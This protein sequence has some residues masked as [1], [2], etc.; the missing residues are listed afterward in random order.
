MGAGRRPAARGLRARRAPRPWPNARVPRVRRGR[1]P[2][3][4]AVGSA[5]SNASGKAG[6]AELAG[7]LLLVVGSDPIYATGGG[8]MR[9]ARQVAA[10]AA[11]AACA[12]ASPWGRPAGGRAGGE[13]RAAHARAAGGAPGRP[14]HRGRATLGARSPTSR[15]GAA[16]PASPTPTRS[17]SPPTARCTWSRD[18]SST[19]TGTRTARSSCSS[20]RRVLARTGCPPAR[21]RR[22]S[23]TW[24]HLPRA[25]PRRAERVLRLARRSGRL[26]PRR[27]VERAVVIEMLARAASRCA[28]RLY[29]R[30]IAVRRPPA[31][32]PVARPTRAPSRAGKLDEASGLLC[33]LEQNSLRGFGY[34]TFGRR[35]V[36]LLSRP[37]R[38]LASEVGRVRLPRRLGRVV[39]RRAAACPLSGSSA[40][41]RHPWACG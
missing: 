18:S 41:C 26:T 38:L 6:L 27:A 36:L 2:R 24:L 40:R 35:A 21:A 16:H 1:V 12:G 7:R 23:A 28:R 30:G 20:M 17:W 33:L 3:R 14:T 31:R 10:A 13:R 39:L 9:A 4:H 5:A 29:P 19:S 32:P 37:L 25:H 22:S 15:P 34:E 11:A 8:R